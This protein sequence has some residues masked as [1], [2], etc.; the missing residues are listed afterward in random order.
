MDLYY[1]LYVIYLILIL[2]CVFQVALLRQGT[3]RCFN[4][5]PYRNSSG[6]L[7]SLCHYCKYYFYSDFWIWNWSHIAT[8]LVDLLFFLLGRCCSKKPEAVSDVS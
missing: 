8:V 3:G 2:C 6:V 4:L 1:V 7:S 5:V